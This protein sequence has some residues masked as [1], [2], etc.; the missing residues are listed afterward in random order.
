MFG[1]SIKP[2]NGSI[3]EKPTSSSTMYRTLGAPSGAIG[4]AYGSQS[5]FE[6]LMSMLM[7][8]LNGLLIRHLLSG[9]G[10]WTTPSLGVLL[11]RPSRI[12][13]RPLDLLH[14]GYHSVRR[15]TACPLGG[16]AIGR[17]FG[18]AGGLDTGEI[19]ERRTE[20]GRAVR[21]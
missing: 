18:S 6:S 5:G 21:S 3:A 14:S 12:P 20:A 13:V 1:V 7:T 16:R 2:P 10:S 19:R 11:G 17:G 9:C 4:W 15:S 8:P